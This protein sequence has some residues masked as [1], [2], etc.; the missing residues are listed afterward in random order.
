M[1]LQKEFLKKPDKALPPEEHLDFKKFAEG[2]RSSFAPE[3][4]N[5]ET[6]TI[7]ANQVFAKD[8]DLV[9]AQILR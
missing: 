5:D 6:L 9:I 4:R 8:G 1:P 7:M 3:N 2:L